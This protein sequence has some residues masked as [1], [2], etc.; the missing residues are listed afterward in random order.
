MSAIGRYDY[1]ESTWR[2][3]E[4]ML[5]M[6]VPVRSRLERSDKPEDYA[7]VD[8]VYYVDASYPVAV[9]VRPNRPP[10]APNIDVTYRITEPAKIAAGTYAPLLLFVWINDGIAT[11]GKLVDVYG[12]YNRTRDI[13]RAVQSNGDGTAWF[14]VKIEELYATRGLLRQGDRR[15]WAPAWYGAN[16]QTQRIIDRHKTA[17]PR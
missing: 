7:G 4:I 3:I 10:Y 16:E 13:Q 5:P 15:E 8:A 11:H 2:E 6:A 9:R 1:P 14:P 12:W 17:G